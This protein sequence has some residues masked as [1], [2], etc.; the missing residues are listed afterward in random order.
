MV[1]LD[2]MSG[3]LEAVYPPRL[4]V[5]TTLPTVSLLIGGQKTGS[6]SGALWVK[7]ISTQYCDVLQGHYVP[8][9]SLTGQLIFVLL[10]RAPP[11]T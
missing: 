11:P 6:S 4:M 9:A 10:S 7:K 5:S 1:T 2:K 8:Q 3:N